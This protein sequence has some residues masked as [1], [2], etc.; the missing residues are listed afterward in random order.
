MKRRMLA[1]LGALTMLVGMVIVT[2]PPVAAQRFG[3]EA[4][5]AKDTNVA[6][7]TPWGT[8]D[9]QGIWG[10]PFNAPLQRLKKYAGRERLTPEEVK[11]LN[12][13]RRPSIDR[14]FRPTPGKA[15]EADVAGAYNAI[16]GP[17]QPS[18]DRTSLIVDPPDGRLPPTTPEFRKA[19]AAKRAHVL[20]TMQATDQCKNKED[21]KKKFGRTS[22]E[23]GTYDANAPKRSDP[24]PDYNL[25]GMNRADGPEDNPMNVRCLGNQLPAITAMQR[26]VQS[27]DAVAIFYDIGQGQGFSRVIP[28][29][30]APHLAKGVPQRYGDARGRWEGDTLVVDVT[31]FSMKTN[32]Q[33]SRQNLH[34]IERFTRTGPNTLDY[35]STIDDPTVWTKPWTVLIDMRRMQEKPNQI[36]QQTCHEGNYG[37]VGMLAGARAAEQAFAEG[38]GPNPASIDLFTTSGFFRREDDDFFTLAD[39][40]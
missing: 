9:L 38:R 29:S 14:D 40:E 4:P 30:N 20:G 15:T 13:R 1:L 2:S 3:P 22:C 26:I 17:G 25:A 6:L 32:F 12:D 7:K 5:F 27:P 36:Y 33:G 35:K 31:N 8:P 39:A 28:I 21:F 24:S 23:G 18:S 16:W 10:F 11:A 19:G 34:L 37:Q